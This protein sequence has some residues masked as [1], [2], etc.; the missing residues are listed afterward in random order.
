MLD[1]SEISFIY[2]RNK[3]GPKTL[4]WGTPCLMIPFSDS[5]PLISVSVSSFLPRRS[6]HYQSRRMELNK[7]LRDQCK[8]NGFVFMANSNIEMEHHLSDDG[9]HL[10][11]DGSSIICRNLLYH[12][13]KGK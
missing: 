11:S 5:T 13:N 4:P 7:L 12:L 3:S 1:D 10:N 8:S 2:S 6:L 9:V